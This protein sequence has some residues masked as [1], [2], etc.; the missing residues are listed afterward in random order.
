MPTVL[1]E[2]EVHMFAAE[3][4]L[5]ICQWRSVISHIFQIPELSKVTVKNKS[6][7]MVIMM[8]LNDDH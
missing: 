4:D 7:L 8:W 3:L 2:V 5:F 6:K 1:K